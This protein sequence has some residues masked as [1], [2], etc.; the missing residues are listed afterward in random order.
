M[1]KENNAYVTSLLIRACGRRRRLL[2]ATAAE[3]LST[4]TREAAGDV[5]A[6]AAVEAARV[7]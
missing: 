3:S 7:H 1:V 5:H 4:A 2:A 6:R